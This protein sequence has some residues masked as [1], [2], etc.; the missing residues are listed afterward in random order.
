MMQVCLTRTSTSASTDTLD[1]PDEKG[2]TRI[3]TDYAGS[4]YM[5]VHVAETR[6]RALEVM[7]A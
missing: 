5:E 6:R 1:Q 7:H 3:I 4:Y 2:G